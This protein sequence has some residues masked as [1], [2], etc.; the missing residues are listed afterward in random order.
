[1]LPEQILKFDIGLFI[2]V[3]GPAFILGSDSNPS[4]RVGVNL[5]G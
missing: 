4:T 5:N 2:D 3:Y 1:M